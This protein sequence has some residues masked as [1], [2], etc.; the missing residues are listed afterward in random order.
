MSGKLCPFIASPAHSLRPLTDSTSHAS[1]LSPCLH[2]KIAKLASA[3]TNQPGSKLA[4]HPSR[5]FGQ[6]ASYSQACCIH[7]RDRLDVS[8]LSK[9]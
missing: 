2:M 6:S 1:R 9:I 7:I 5:K 4:R 3:E 8:I